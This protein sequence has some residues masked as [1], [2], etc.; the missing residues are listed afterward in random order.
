MTEAQD[1]LLKLFKE[2]DEVCRKNDLKYYLAGG[3]LVGAIRH[4]GF[5]PWDDDADIHMLIDDA[6]KLADYVAAQK[7]P[8]RV[9]YIKSPSGDYMNAHW[10]YEDESKT[11]LMR[12]LTGSEGSQGQFID[13]FVVYPLPEDEELKQQCLD[14]FEIYLELKSQN[15]VVNSRRTVEYLNRYFEFKEREAEIGKAELLEE[16]ESRIF[17]YPLE[18]AKEGFLCAP[19][20]AERVVPME[21]WGEPRYVKFEDMELPI[22]QYAEKFLAYEYGPQWFEVPPYTDRGE[23]VFVEDFDIPYKVYTGEFNKYL[24]IKEFYDHE[25]QKKE[26]WFDIIRTRNI[27]NPHVRFLQ[28]ICTSL[29]IQHFVEK[30][31]IDVM[32]LVEKGD[33]ATLDKIF[34]Q[35]Y[36]RLRGSAFKYWELSIDMPDDFLYAAHYFSCH[37]GSYGL[38]RKELEYRRESI[39]RELSPKLQ[40]LCDLCDATDELLYALFA[41]LDYDKARELVDTWVEKEP[42]ALYFLRAKEYLDLYHSDNPD[43]EKVLD[44]CDKYLELYN[45]DGELMKYKGDALLKLGKKEEGELCYKKALNTLKNGFCITEIKDYFRESAVQ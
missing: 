44:D 14:D 29:E 23:H 42:E 7:D 9:V 24:D 8:N 45:N 1:N 6:Q 11:L 34:H 35:Y 3:S 26:Y 19:F 37:N 17:N 16:I 10:R 27:I 18:G 38:A 20:P 32:D 36:S 43:Y 28:G 13:I 41:D 2:F 15:T 31:N 5:L 21:W 40:E 33:K 12:G 4:G 25:V 22:P 30:Y 39:D